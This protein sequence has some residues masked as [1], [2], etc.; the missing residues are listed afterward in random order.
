LN[1]LFSQVQAIINNISVSSPVEDIMPSLLRMCDQKEVS[2]YNLL[3]ASYLDPHF[4]TLGGCKAYGSNPLA[5][6]DA[7]N[8]D[9]TIMPRGVIV[10][11]SITIEQM[12]PAGGVL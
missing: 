6:M 4:A 11:K 8:Y 5:G 1:G 10:P 2:K 9:A 7:V 3:T 12:T